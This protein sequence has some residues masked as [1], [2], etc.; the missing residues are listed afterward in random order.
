MLVG[1]PHF[2]DSISD[3]TKLVLVNAVHLSSE[4]AEAFDPADT[5]EEEFT[6]ASGRVLGGVPTMVGRQTSTGYELVRGQSGG[7]EVLQLP[8]REGALSMVVVL[9]PRGAGEC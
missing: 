3:N 8:L 9:P 6:T 4:W 7:V 2:A 1:L 5:A